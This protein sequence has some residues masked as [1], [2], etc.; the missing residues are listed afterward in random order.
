MNSKDT[1]WLQL[2]ITRGIGPRT[3]ARVLSS[4]VGRGL[5]P[6]DVGKVTVNDWLQF[7]LKPAKAALVAAARQEAEQ[8]RE[9]LEVAGTHLLVKGTASYPGRLARYGGVEAPPLLFARGK[10]A[11]LER[12][13]VAF[14]GSRHASEQGLEWTQSVAARLATEQINVVSGY[15]NGVDL[16]AHAAAL[17]AGGGTTFVLAEGIL[18]FTP[19]PDVAELLDEQGHLILSE[20][21]PRASWSVGNAMQRNGTVLGLADAVVVVEAGLGGGTLAAGAAALKMGRPLFVVD[22]PKPPSSAGGNRLLVA[23]GARPLPG[24]ENITEAVRLLVEAIRASERQQTPQEAPVPPEPVQR[25]LF[26][27]IG[28]LR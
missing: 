8:L 14:C 22:Y 2:L 26:D 6:A 9:R 5:D 7:G 1:T 24:P 21:P 11:L 13:A 3:V 12:S 19:K 20:F 28:K 23:R 15:A 27:E 17:R 4:V 10:I 25:N 18:R 16:H